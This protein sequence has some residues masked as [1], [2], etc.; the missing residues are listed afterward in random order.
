[1]P[2]RLADQLQSV[3]G[4]NGG[5][6]RGRIGALASPCLQQPG[7]REARQHGL[8]QEQLRLAGNQSTAELRQHR[9]IEPGIGQL[10]GQSILPVDAT[11]NGVGGLVID[12][13]FGVLQH[14]DQGQT[15]RSQGRTTTR[16]EERGKGGVFVEHP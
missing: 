13:P 7:G 12:E 11:A 15:P 1:M 4:A 10:E 8:E 5:Q 6:D 2:Q 16:G 14:E 3:E 9:G